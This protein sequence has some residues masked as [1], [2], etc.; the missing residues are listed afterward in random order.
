MPSDEFP[1]DTFILYPNYFGICDKNVE[2]LA[3]KYS[4][5]LVDNAHS[6][7]SAPKGFAAFNS[8]RKFLK[9]YNGSYLWIK[10]NSLT[11]PK[12]KIFHPA[13]KNEEEIYKNERKFDLAEIEILNDITAEEIE[14]TDDMKVRKET[15]LQLHQTYGSINLLNIDESVKSPFCYPCLLK[16][17][18]DAD[19]LCEELKSD[20][21]SIY[22]YWEKLPE[23]FNEYKFFSRLV[24]IPLSKNL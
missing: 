8:A 19:E 22:R 20:G 9:V 21:Y 11:F 7:Y 5:L 6:F 3:R 12:E 10:D 24:P 18:A 17:E 23:D 15:F 16:T 4:R 13:P 2:I 1:V 14:K